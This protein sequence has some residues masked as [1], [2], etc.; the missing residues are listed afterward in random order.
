M[1]IAYALDMSDP[2]TSGGDQEVQCATLDE[3]FEHGKVV[4]VRKSWTR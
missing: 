3:A 4:E 1:F 2:A